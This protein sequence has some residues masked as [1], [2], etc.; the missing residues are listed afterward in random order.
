MWPLDLHRK[1]YSA[2]EA[3]K[4]IA[5]LSPSTDF[6]KLCEDA[7]S[8]KISRDSTR[9]WLQ[10]LDESKI[11]SNLTEL[12]RRL[13]QPRP[14][15][16]LK[17]REYP[18]LALFPS[19]KDAQ[20]RHLSALGWLKAAD[21]NDLPSRQHIYE[22]TAESYR[23]LSNILNT[24]V[25]SMA[26][27]R[28]DAQSWRLN[29]ENLLREAELAADYERV[30]GAREA[31][32]GLTRELTYLKELTRRHQKFKLKRLLP[33]DLAF[34][35]EDEFKR[36]L[37]QC[38]GS[39]SSY[40]STRAH[41]PPSS[42][43]HSSSLGDAQMG[44]SSQSQLGSSGSNAQ[45]SSALG[46]SS[47][48]GL[49]AASMERRQLTR[50]IND[51]EMSQ[52]NYRRHLD[53]LYRDNEALKNRNE[54]LKSQAST[55][56]HTQQGQ[57]SDRKVRDL[58]DQL[59][60]LQKSYHQAIAQKEEYS[61]HLEHSAV[62]MTEVQQER[63]KTKQD[64]SKM[65]TEMESLRSK[66]EQSNLECSAV[67]KELEEAKVRASKQ[68][69]SLETLQRQLEEDRLESEGSV[70]TMAE[71]QALLE[72]ELRLA[73][74]KVEDAVKM[75]KSAEERMK[76][77]ENKLTTLEAERDKFMASKSL[78]ESELA[79]KD[80]EVMLA[81]SQGAENQKALRQQ[82]DEVK[83]EMDALMDSTH[84]HVE[85]IHSLEDKNAELSELLESRDSAIEER[86]ARIL[87]LQSDYDSQFAKTILIEEEMTALK[88]EREQSAWDA[89][90]ARQLHDEA[91][92]GV[93]PARPEYEAKTKAELINIVLE[94]NHRV[95]SMHDEF[96]LDLERAKNHIALIEQ[97]LAAAHNLNAELLRQQSLHQSKD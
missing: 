11:R 5:S 65:Q 79:Q 66:L 15:V 87:K 29:G 75:H 91:A 51:L 73:R 34:L 70:H 27:G 86:T 81:R 4:L 71:S 28:L 63:E 49:L 78:L 94:Q 76:S 6:N 30:A 22:V 24:V 52:A 57:E 92:P 45:G 97:R 68:S 39:A 20:T 84:K 3:Q 64:L 59:T 31:Y 74:S 56:Q 40:A 1:R 93:D 60:S 67:R 62:T 47:I 95:E 88:R 10:S 83:R 69:I 54:M 32:E 35:Y 61:Q 8:I 14:T 96:A 90:F 23:L 46:P 50:R 33:I 72:N 12:S 41:L 19:L 85:K 89:K 38:G 36:A 26:L 16:S 77:L 43:S 48:D 44:T 82:I 80:A 58:E 18:T 7:N 13:S 55:S 53:S 21:E 2:L 42:I 9:S 25:V 37:E 17:L